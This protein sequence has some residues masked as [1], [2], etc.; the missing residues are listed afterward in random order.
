[1]TID[2]RG[3]RSGESKSDAERR[4]AREGTLASEKKCSCFEHATCFRLAS[5]RHCRGGEGC[6]WC[7][8]GRR[9][10]PELHFSFFCSAPGW[11]VAGGTNHGA[12]SSGPMDLR[13]VEAAEDI[14]R[15]RRAGFRVELPLPLPSGSVACRDCVKNVRVESVPLFPPGMLQCRR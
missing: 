6:E 14:E 7:A 11:A 10:I 3:K 13:K 4:A 2:R 8:W 1:M 9:A 15:T 12:H 5:E